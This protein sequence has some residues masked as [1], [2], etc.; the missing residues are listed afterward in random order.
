MSDIHSCSYFCER[1]AC[2]LQQRNE[3]REEML[4][5]LEWKRGQQ[6]FCP[7]SGGSA[8][9]ALIRMTAAAP[10]MLEAL[11]RI[12]ETNVYVGAIAQQMVDEAIAKAEGL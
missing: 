6:L 8:T 1:P 2:V 11:K 4:A 5:V 12:R 10:D 3:L 7:G 9:E